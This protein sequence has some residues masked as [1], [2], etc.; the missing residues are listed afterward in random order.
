MIGNLLLT[1]SHLDLLTIKKRQGQLFAELQTELQPC[2]VPGLALRFNGTPPAKTKRCPPR[3]RP[4][5]VEILSNLC[6]PEVNISVAESS[7]E[8]LETNFISLRR[9]NLHFFNHQRLPRLPCHRSCIF[10]QWNQQF[11][12]N[13]YRVSLP[14]IH[15]LLRTY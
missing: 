5:K 11:S 6:F 14:P 7:E 9:R 4:L 3:Y 8:D 2:Y 12:S 13:S 1:S 10:T 15:L